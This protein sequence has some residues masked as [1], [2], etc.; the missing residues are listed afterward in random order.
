[1]KGLRVSTAGLA[2]AL[3]A[4][5]CT[6]DVAPIPVAT[7]AFPRALD[8]VLVGQKITIPAVV[9]DGAN[10]ELKNRKITYEASPT[11]VA[12]VTSTGE[13]TGLAAAAATITATSE[14]KSTTMG[15]RVLSPA[16]RV[17]I[18]PPNSDITLGNSRQLT[19]TALNAGNEA[20]AGRTVSW[21]SS[22]NSVATVNAAGQVFAVALGTATITATTDFERTSTGTGA[23]GTAVVNI[24]DPVNSVRMTP[25]LPQIMRPGN[26]LQVSAQPLNVAGQP[27]TRPVTW[28]TSN[29]TVATVDQNGLVTAIAL[30]A[31]SIVAESENRQ[32][33][34]N[35]TVLPVPVARV[36]LSPTDTVRVFVNGQQQLTFVAFDASNNPLTLAGR[37]VAWASDNLPVVQVSAAGVVAGLSAGVGKVSVTVDQV[38]SNETPVKVSLVPV[39]TVTVN[40][41][42]NT[43]TVG[44]TQQMAATLR[45]ANGNV[46]TNRP[47]VWSVSDASK[48]TITQAGVLLGVAAGQVT[49]TATSEGVSG[50][51]TVTIIP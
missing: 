21:R 10:N 19:F 14:G 29:P 33:V 23:T 22:D 5:G 1:M 43:L 45:D 13:I 47:V 36:E 24:T 30:G 38:K 35:I 18:A 15:V 12:S 42:G 6:K 4:F 40:P 41:N 37:T 7:I 28:S 16:T 48:A 25:S 17:V 27:V 49:V 11:N 31:V 2:F 46:L 51:A 39:A 32:G 50:T 34:L 20:L 8:S 26:T 9:R 3:A 44:F